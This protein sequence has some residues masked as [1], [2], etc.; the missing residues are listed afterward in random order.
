M[1][2]IFIGLLIVLNFLEP[3]ILKTLFSDPQQRITATLISL[4]FTRLIV[5]PW[6]LIG[7]LRASDKDFLTHGNTNKSRA[8]Q[9]VMILGIGYS[10]AYSVA[11][12]QSASFN[13]KQT[14]LAT[15]YQE[16]L[17]QDKKYQFTFRNDKTQLVI[18]GE[19]EIGITKA[20]INILKGNPQISSIALNSIGGHIYEGRG[21]SK[22]FTRLGLDTYVY[23][24]CSSA[25]TT[26]FSGGVKRYLGSSGQLGF[27]QYKHDLNAHK[28][29]VA[30]YDA[31]EEQVRDLELFRSRGI[32]PVF[33]E[34][35][36]NE[37]S[38]R[39]WFPTHQELISARMINMIIDTK[40]L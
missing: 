7:L 4:V 34:K 39:M 13:K 15:E 35:I 38:D 3:W 29:S 32:D 24:K 23:Q 10:L 31:T 11:L 16:L 5:F 25:C 6:Q 17:K 30:F 33:L 1:L 28:K 8:I 20:V 19:L 9:L 26:A 2:I 37:S 18:S 36:F 22:L 21:L 14:E 12:I 27:H 40:N